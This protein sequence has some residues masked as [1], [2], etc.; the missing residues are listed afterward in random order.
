MNQGGGLSSLLASVYVNRRGRA[1][2]G[3]SFLHFCEIL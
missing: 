2:M 3:S 1:L